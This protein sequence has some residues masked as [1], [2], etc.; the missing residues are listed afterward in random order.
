M[1]AIL[2]LSVAAHIFFFLLTPYS[3]S[4]DFPSYRS[5]AETIF[6][7]MPDAARTP[8]YPILL[9]LI[10]LLVPN[11]PGFTLLVTLVQTTLFLYTIPKF[12][13]AA[14]QIAPVSNTAFY[15]TI[16]YATC[17]HIIYWNRCV[18][19]ESLSIS[20]TVL[21]IYLLFR[22]LGTQK[23]TYLPTL[24][25]LSAALI[26][27]RPS[28]LYLI[29]VILI[30]L[31]A[32]R[33]FNKGMQS[34]AGLC[35]IG[36]IGGLLYLYAGTIKKET[37]V[38]TLSTVSVINEYIGQRMMGTLQPDENS[39]IG[40]D[41]SRMLKENR[42]TPEQEIA[43]LAEQY[44]YR[45][46]ARQTANARTLPETAKTT[47]LRMA[48]NGTKLFFIPGG[49][50]ESDYSTV[51]QL[52]LKAIVA[53]NI[54]FLQ[55]YLFLFLIFAYLFRKYIRN[56]QGDYV[57]TYPALIA[58]LHTVVV[59]AGAYGQYSRLM[60]PLYPV[61]LLLASRFIENIYLKLKH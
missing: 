33:H 9:A 26:M 10:R 18:M 17:P 7:G 43:L 61:V 3:V 44:G 48:Q 25:L 60:A 51:G 2:L 50:V 57:M 11:E 37:G 29:P 39:D 53:I 15:L 47:F 58:I 30:H 45:E 13:A 52:L 22:H 14:K 8:L 16:A 38:F 28:F 46:I 12:H 19:T 35:G 31:I 34:L 54:N 42:T 4:D 27:L 23:K 36:I 1:T 21:F 24:I 5:A 40:N 55:F 6:N 59:F 20:G 56:R 49:F 32:I 41:M